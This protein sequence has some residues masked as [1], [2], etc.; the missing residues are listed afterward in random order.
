MLFMRKQNDRKAE[1]NQE[2]RLESE[3]GTEILI[4]KVVE[5]VHN[6]QCGLNV[7]FQM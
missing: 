5:K 6:N 1:N 2:Q 3:V 7:F 4:G